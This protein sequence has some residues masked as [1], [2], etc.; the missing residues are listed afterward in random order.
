MTAEGLIGDDVVFVDG[1]A[2]RVA[3]HLGNVVADLDLEG[4]GAADG[5]GV[6]V[7]ELDQSAEIQAADVAIR[8]AVLQVEVLVGSR[9]GRNAVGKEVVRRG[10]VKLVEKLELVLACG[11]SCSGGSKSLNSYLPSENTSSVNTVRS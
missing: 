7:A 5:V 9:K 6:V 10:V 3:L 11:G 1:E 4:V 8:I 2:D